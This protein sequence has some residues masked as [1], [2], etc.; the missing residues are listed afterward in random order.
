MVVSSVFFIS[1]KRQEPTRLSQSKSPSPL[2]ADINSLREPPVSEGVPAGVSRP[3]V[4]GVAP[5]GVGRLPVNGGVPAGASAAC[6][7][8]IID[9]ARKGQTNN[10]IFEIPITE[11]PDI[12]FVP[13]FGNTYV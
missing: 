5:A 11:I 10:R 3:P 4:N 2:S 7:T 8:F 13:V 9:E 1:L 6:Y 12:I